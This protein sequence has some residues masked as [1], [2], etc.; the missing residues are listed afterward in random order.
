MSSLR[1]DHDVH[2]GCGAAHPA[3]AKYGLRGDAAAGDRLVRQARESDGR[4]L[5]QTVLGRVVHRQ[6]GRH[7]KDTSF[8]FNASDSECRTVLAAW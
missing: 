6:W 7:R 2:R 3:D 4:T 5:L 8:R 1:A